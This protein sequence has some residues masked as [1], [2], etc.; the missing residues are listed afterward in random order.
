MKWLVSEPQRVCGS[1]V[2][3]VSAVG[4]IKIL[5]T[6]GLLPIYWQVK[7]DPGVSAR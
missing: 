6:L 1:R 4:G 2:S 3:A 5:K 7:P